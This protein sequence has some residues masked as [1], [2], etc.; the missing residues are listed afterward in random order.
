MCRTGYFG[1]RERFRGVH[2]LDDR[3]FGFLEVLDEGSDA[4]EVAFE[5]VDVPLEQELV[6]SVSIGLSLGGLPLRLGRHSGTR[7]F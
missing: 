7:A 6:G 2:E 1:D 3:G 5:H 4:W